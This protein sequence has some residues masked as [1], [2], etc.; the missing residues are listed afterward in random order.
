LN[1][2]STDKDPDNDTAV[3]PS[4]EPPGS[5]NTPSTDV[6][7]VNDTAVPPAEPLVTGDDAHDDMGWLLASE[8]DGQS[9]S[10][11]IC[12][13]RWRNAR[14]EARKKIFPLFSVSGV[15]LVVCRHGHVLYVC[16]MIR[17]GE[18]LSFFPCFQVDKS[19]SYC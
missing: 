16:D 10:L 5:S 1:T 13:E 8:D 19:H 2:P 7:P 4:A 12:V 15:F 3:P 11:A 6:D 18:L 14:P 9:Q 17:S